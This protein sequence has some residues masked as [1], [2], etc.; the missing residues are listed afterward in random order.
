M[1][2]AEGLIVVRIAVGLELGLSHCQC[3]CVSLCRHV[4]PSASILS[5]ASL[6]EGSTDDQFVLFLF[7]PKDWK[8]CRGGS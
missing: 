8:E 7:F 5:H 2:E 6:G 4:V 3:V 1:H